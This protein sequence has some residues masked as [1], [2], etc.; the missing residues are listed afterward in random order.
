MYGEHAFA[1][2]LLL[3]RELSKKEFIAAQHVLA[4]AGR[5][6]DVLH[7]HSVRDGSSGNDGLV[8]AQMAQAQIRGEQ[9]P[10]GIP[11]RG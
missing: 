6:E 5:R 7:A 11:A 10:S 8:E 1:S 4:A 9:I 3:L 2:L